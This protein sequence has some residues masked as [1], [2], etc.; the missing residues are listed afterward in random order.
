MN[1][2]VTT[3]LVFMVLI[4]IFFLPA[5]NRTTGLNNAKTVNGIVTAPNGD[6]IV[7]ATVYIP[8]GE[9]VSLMHTVIRTRALNLTANDA[10]PCDDPDVEACAVTCTQA[11]GSYTLDTS[12]CAGQE[13]TI[14]AKKGVLRTQIY[15]DCSSDP[16]NTDISFDQEGTQYPKVAVVTGAWDNMQSVL[17]KI[18]PGA[19]R[20]GTLEEYGE[21][22]P[23]AKLSLLDG[24]GEPSATS[25]AKYL[26][27]T[28]SLSEFDIVFINCGVSSFVYEDLIEDDVV[29]ERI[30]NY[31]N[32][33]GNLYVTDF[34]YYFIN[35]VFPSFMQFEGDGSDPISKGYIG[36]ARRGTSGVTVDAVVNDT[37]MKAWLQKV[38]VIQH[39]ANTPGLPDDDCVFGAEEYS[40]RIGALNPEGTIP[41][42][43]FLPGWAQMIATY[44]NTDTKIWVSSGAGAVFDGLD[45]RP[46]T[47][48]GTYGKG[49]IFYSSYHTAETCKTKYFWPQERVLQFLIFE[50]F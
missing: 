25:F 27:G 12:G 35:Q 1:K 33:G 45:N 47:V 42:G 21:I 13:K 19:S 3:I 5:C 14:I 37:T 15:L 31:V 8:S 20:Y 50:A 43:D 4:E 32:N 29:K 6:I 17:V 10:T 9:D 24:R 41:I 36:A 39:D 46:L 30:R 38:R 11:D 7:G 28:Y 16:C 26:D 44:P 48:S 49:K 40:T 18:A 23:G 34:S 22:V 2:C